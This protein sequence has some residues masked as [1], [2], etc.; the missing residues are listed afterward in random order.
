M[1]WIAASAA[2]SLTMRIFQESSSFLPPRVK[3]VVVLVV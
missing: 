2:P 1:Q 3:N